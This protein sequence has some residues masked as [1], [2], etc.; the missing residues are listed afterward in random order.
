MTLRFAASLHSM[1][2]VALGAAAL[3]IAAS[4]GAGTISGTVVQNDTGAPLAAM[5][6]AAYT[7]A[8]VL[9]ASGAT[10][11]SGTY[12]L[13]IQAGTYHL[14]A[15]DPT[16]NHAT[17]FYSD[18]E[19]FETSASVVLTATQNLT[20]LSFRLVAAGYAAGHVTAADGT[21]LAGM[22]V[23]AYNLSGTRRT[24]TTTDAS[25][26]F[27][28]TLPPGQFK[29]AAYDDN[30]GYVTSFYSGQPTFTA[31]TPVAI[32]AGSST[33]VDMA[34]ARAAALSGTITDRTTL[35]PLPSMRV[36]VYGA[37]GA[38]RAV[39][40]TGG[41]GY[42]GVAITPDTV[43][44]VIDDPAGNYAPTY[45]P[46]AESFQAAAQIAAGAGETFTIDATLLRG[47]RVTGRVVD[48]LSALPIAAISVAAYNAD[49]SIRSIVAT[50]ATG[51]YTIVVPPGQYRIG[52]FDT[53]LVYLSLFYPN[54]SLF[55][56]AT[57]AY[58]TQ[59]QTTAGLDFALAKGTRVSGRTMS[60]STG[61]PLAG[62]TVGAYD[63]NGQ[64]IVSSL[65]GPNGA[66]AL[67]LA[68]GT[69]KLLAFDTSLQFATTYAG[70][71]P[72]F[73][74]TATIVATEGLTLAADFTMSAAG[75]VSGL[76]VDAATGA[77]L[78]AAS[79]FAYDA[80]GNEVL[81][82]TTNA[83]GAYRLALLPGVYRIAAAN[84]FRYPAQF[85]PGVPTFS[86]AAV[87]SVSV[88]QEDSGIDIRLLAATTG[89]RR[90]AAAH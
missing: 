86:A 15:Y 55:A 33:R 70:G 18:A 29:V 69:Y 79:I 12:A 10:T 82:A 41:N 27:T 47:G 32:A 59:Q 53:A 17:S 42:F 8:G 1:K 80:N 34:L 64:L 88:G 81:T 43:R 52:A 40:L 76:I 68:P 31:A 28:L 3:L 13:T 78:A 89:F 56:A 66:Y 83:S 2:A 5:T 16:G 35:A 26:A 75:R 25:G 54:Q 63:L 14:L 61:L 7:T 87:V 21:P 72:S 84:P 44:V 24:F 60:G 58:V 74:S 67:L 11:A 45:Y 22:T 57:P 20:N 73:E 62:I 9:Q 6:V 39:V 19:S 65:S 90:R 4:A 50:D 77:P 51:A 23:V 85:Y 46:D 48:H 71:A 49:G 37:D 38:V 30:L 36:T